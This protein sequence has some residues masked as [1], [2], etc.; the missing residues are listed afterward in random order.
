[1]EF[2][3]LGSVRI[4]G[5]GDPKE[6]TGRM[7][8]TLV[9]VLLAHANQPVAVS[10]LVSALWGTEE[11]ASPGHALQLHVYKL[12]R[13]LDRPDRLVL[14]AEGYRLRVF[15][16]ELDAD[17]FESLIGEAEDMAVQ[18]PE[19][20]VRLLR[21]ALALWRGA[22]YGGTD[23]SALVGETERLA[24]RRLAA[25]ELLYETELRCGR[26][27][28]VIAELTDLVRRHPLRERLH[29][30]LMIALYLAGRQAEALDAYRTARE[31]LVDELG[32]EP[33]P[34]L[35]RIEQRILAGETVAP[36][37]DDR[38]VV[39]A[40]LP[41]DVRGFV[42]RDR[43]LSELD[44]LLTSTEPVLVATIAGTAGVGK[45]ALAVRWAHRVLDRFPDG[46]LYVDLRGYGPDEPV[47]AQD[48]LAGFLR[49]LGMAGA[50]IPTSLSDRAARYRTLL[51]GRR[52]LVV[53]DN[54]RA[55]D[56]VRPL[57]PGGRSCFVLVSSRD[58]LIG[59]GAREG[60]HRVD[61]NRLQTDEALDLF[62]RM[63]G[64][65][66]HAEPEAAAALV[67]RCA[68]LPLA[69][70]VAAEQIKARRGVSVADL[71]DELTDQQHRL[72]ALDVD[73]D[74]HTAVR[75]VFSWSYHHLR[76]DAARV[77][78]L[79]GLHPGHVV[80]PYS[81]AVLGDT[82]PRTSRRALASLSQANLADEDTHG[83]F[84]MHDLMRTYATERVLA[85]EPAEERDAAVHR[86][87]TWYLHT[88]VAARFAIDPRTRRIVLT[89]PPRH[90]PAFDT[91]AAGMRWFKLERPNLVAAVRLAAERAE[92]TLCW[93]L[94]SALLTFFHLDKHWD[95][96]LTTHHTGLASARACGD[97]AGQAHVLN[98]LGVAHSDLEQSTEA[99]AAHREAADLYTRAGDRAGAAWNLNNLGVVYDDMRR[100][101]EAVDCYEASLALF[102]EIAD[103]RGQGLVLCN[104]ADVH[105]QRHEPD[106]AVEALRQAM[107]IQ[108]AAGD[109]YGQRFTRANLGDLHREAGDSLAAEDSYRSALAIAQE[110]GDRWQVARL[111]DRLAETL[112]AAGDTP[113]AD[114]YARE[115]HAMFTDL[116]ARPMAREYLRRAEETP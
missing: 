13:M 38:P 63:T 91:R 103:A 116:R 20:G 58:A 8:R 115:A 1:M 109:L 93:Q 98:G 5:H 21:K 28:A 10:D 81:L 64:E 48:A 44:S 76:P 22:P 51:A 82:D 80:D 90:V 56:Q 14:L 106:R 11:N 54:A 107:T 31:V 34:E 95:D 25:L 88:A 89:D 99:I 78:R 70:R 113:T 57:L 105:R 37:T 114:T 111:L 86:L 53:L 52:M 9:S 46:Q 41:H 100:F 92:H 27:A 102:R 75:A 26:H 77:F 84:E 36:D 6:L 108:E 47:S 32:L 4:R 19:Y 96:W 104:L 45:T 2:E 112:R 12:R 62:L 87:L 73:G 59:L 110:L 16:G 55:L 18:E 85:E 94:T 3:V 71:V 68:R 7:Q 15:P 42:G 39:P 50:D 61:L 83:R 17:R 65:R 97:L 60:A 35:R 101:P 40:Q 23:L 29:G 30:S 79:W 33:G 69:L 66:L 43:E 72:D 24:E 49:A 74:P 67:E